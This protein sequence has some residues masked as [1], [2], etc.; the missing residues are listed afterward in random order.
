MAS[1][2]KVEEKKRRSIIKKAI[3]RTISTAAYETLV[4]EDGFEEEIEWSSLAERSKKIDNWTTVLLTQYKQSHDRILTELGF[5]HK[6]AFFKNPSAT[7]QEKFQEVQSDKPELDL[8]D[9]DS[10]G[11]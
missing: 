11:S 3:R 2:K 5:E 7:T 9:L 6:K 1:D 4:I 8:D 10:I